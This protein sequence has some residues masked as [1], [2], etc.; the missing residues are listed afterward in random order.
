MHGAVWTSRHHRAAH[1]VTPNEL[2]AE[3]PHDVLWL[4]IWFVAG[5]DG[6]NLDR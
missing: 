2:C 5:H 4:L 1:T 3:V 6:L